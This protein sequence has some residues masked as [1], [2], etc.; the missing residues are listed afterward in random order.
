MRFRLSFMRPDVFDPGLYGE[1]GGPANG[2]FAGSGTNTSY[3]G[4]GTWTRVFSAKTVLD[5]RGGL[6]YYH[7]VTSTTA[8]GLTTSADVGIPGA[9]IDEFTSGLSQISIGGYSDPVLGF[10]ASQPWDRSEKTWSFNGVLTRLL[11]SHTV[12]VGGEYRHNDDML[13]QTQ[14]AGGPRG[15]FA[16]NSSGTGNPADAASTTSIANSFAAFLLDWPNTVQRDLKVFD[17]PGTKHTGLFAFAQDKWQVRSNVTVDLGLRWEYYT[18]LAGPR[19]GGQPVQLRSGDAHA[20]RLGVR[21]HGRSAEREEE[22]HQLLAADRRVLAPQRQERGACGIRRQHDSVPGQPLRVQ[23]PGQADLRGDRGQRVPAGRVDG[24][25]LPATGAA[26]HS[27]ERH[28]SGER[29][30]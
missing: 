8:N 4:A 27:V 7:N 3:S 19:G 29:Q 23:L 2:G 16:F 25:R 18:P 13:L 5:V 28:H 17:R 14:D 9:N 24:H 21:R 26:R 22:V 12:K 20:A 6:N 11:Q 10:S 15:R 1:Y 30:R